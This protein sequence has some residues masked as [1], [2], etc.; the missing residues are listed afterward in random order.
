MNEA[1]S[2][3]NS[4]FFAVVSG[5]TYSNLL[6]NNVM[7]LLC[8]EPLHFLIYSKK[9]R[10]VALSRAYFRCLFEK[11]KSTDSNVVHISRNDLRCVGYYGG[12]SSKPSAVCLV[13]ITRP[14]CH[15]SIGQ[16]EGTL[17]DGSQSEGWDNTL[18]GDTQ[19]F[20]SWLTFTNDYQWKCFL[21]NVFVLS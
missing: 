2:W 5:Q 13:L 17:W 18:P 7:H 1:W 12:W 8:V 14:C 10:H 20:S 21:K 11:F 9:S 6:Q 3:G 16:S 15:V 19:W 4:I